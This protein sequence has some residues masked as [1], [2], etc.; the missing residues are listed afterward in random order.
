MLSQGAL[1]AVDKQVFGTKVG[2]GY[3]RCLNAPPIVRDLHTRNA[4]G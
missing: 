2:G 3:L 1:Y 4:V